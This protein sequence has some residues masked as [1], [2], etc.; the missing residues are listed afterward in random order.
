M[1]LV[2]REERFAYLAEK[3][4][5][6]IF[7]EQTAETV[8][9]ETMPEIARIL[10]TFGTLLVQ[11]K[12]VE[13]GSVRVTGGIQA[14]VLYLPEGGDQPER[15]EVWI[16]F[17]L[18]KK[19]ATEENTTLF[20]W[21]WIRSLETR[22][23][24]SRKVL[25]KAGIGSEITLLT[26]TEGKTA[27]LDRIPE[28]L[29]CRTNQYPMRL[30]LAAAEKELQ[31]AD[32][33]LM[34]EQ[35][36]GID[37]LLKTNCRVEIEECRCIGSKA[38]FKGNLALRILYTTEAGPLAA[39]EGTV[40]FSQYA[41][42]DREVE[43][44]I[45]VVQPIF[46]HLELDSD[47]QPDSHRLLLNTTVQA[48]MVVR[49]IVELKLTEDAYCLSGEW[50]PQWQTVELTPCLDVVDRAL[51]QTIQMPENASELL[52]STCFADRGAYTDDAPLS[53]SVRV[54]LLYYDADRKLQN[55]TLTQS[56]REFGP[57]EIP[58]EPICRLDLT[59][60]PQQAG[61]SV[62]IPLRAQMI[63]LKRMSWQNLCGG[64]MESGQRTEGPS[65]VVKTVEGDLWSLAKEYR[66]T[67]RAICAA[68]GLET[69]QIGGPRQLLI[70]TGGMTWGAEGG[71]E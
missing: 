53:G 14:G 63:C 30:P 67:V 8:I 66:T 9:P 41:E 18:Q 24:N 29:E 54:N 69:E 10:D 36:P 61:A 58:P 32:E 5:D 2:F 27:E 52:D 42:L 71:L 56:F 28:G 60:E 50:K 16:P 23:I 37:R 44:G 11:S 49:G 15:I 43:D 33:V 13:N 55:R 25:V 68:N 6:L 1:E 46:R 48:Q 70:P 59:G 21:G 19:T 34:P 35:T 65:L 31:I 26:P 64:T 39:W 7:Q 3:R 20:Y 4:Y 45:V 17:T 47:G 62:R 12:A 38:V 22:F 40:P 57:G 51:P